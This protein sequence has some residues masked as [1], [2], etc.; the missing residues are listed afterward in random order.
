MRYRYRKASF[1]RKKNIYICTY[2]EVGIGIGMD[3][4]MAVSIIS[5]SFQGSSRASLN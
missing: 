3:S 2:I 1:K 5:G 4:D